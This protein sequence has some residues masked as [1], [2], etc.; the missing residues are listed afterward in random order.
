MY[1]CVCVCMYIYI[2]IY[3]Y[4]MFMFCRVCVVCFVQTSR[5]S[6]VIYLRELLDYEGEENSSLGMEHNFF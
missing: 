3:M 1:V 4:D 5:S 2:Y 6:P